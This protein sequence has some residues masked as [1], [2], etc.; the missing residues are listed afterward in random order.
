MNSEESGN[1]RL[2]L[3]NASVLMV[4]QLAT[5]GLSLLLTLFLPRY[6]GVTA[7]GKLHLAESLWSIVG[8]V[9]AFGM[10]T[11]LVKEIARKPE[12]VGDLLGTTMVVRTIFHIIGFLSLVIYARAFHY[13][14]ET[15][16]IIYIMGISSLL[17]QYSGSVTAA[18]QGLERMDFQSIANVVSRAIGTIIS[19]ILLLLGYKLIVI[20]SIIVL[21][22]LA[23]FSIQYILLKKAQGFQLHFTWYQ[24][25]EMVKHSLPLFGVGFFIIVYSQLDVIIISHLVN[26]DGV[27]WYGVADRFFGTLLFVPTVFLTAVF[28]ALSRMFSTSPNSL[29]KL[30]GKSFD[31][32]FVLS[33]PIGLGLI[34]ISNPL[35]IGLFGKEFA[36]T[37]PIL[38]VRG[39]VLIFT[40]Q[41]ILLGQFLISIDRQNPWSIVLAVA[42][43]ATIPLDYL[44]IP[45][46]EAMFSNGAIG[47]ALAYIV[48]EVCMFIIALRLLP[49]GW[50]NR[51]NA[52]FAVK[53]VI[54]GLVML[55]VVWWVKDLFIIIP[56]LVGA[57]TYLI[58]ILVLRIIPKEDWLLIRELAQA[59]LKRGQKLQPKY[60]KTG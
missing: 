45:W 6:L 1:G 8:V 31:L 9:V 38:A 42:T 21:V 59:V 41:N 23:N 5:W 44:F 3:K 16:T 29:P 53:T 49:Q 7:I 33:V 28:P 40:Y 37:A 14:S 32:L 35:V 30:M 46:C 20:V 43:L 47:G 54:A 27:G 18:L 36:N 12:R 52:V 22:A 26:E 55:L 25:K 57:I 19:I 34:A 50:L 2:I 60:S 56:I 24:A 58:M 51:S 13:P 17:G 4:S 48:T 10:D 11:L 15:L 39:I